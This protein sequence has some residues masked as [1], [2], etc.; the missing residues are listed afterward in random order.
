MQ[1]NCFLRG[2]YGY[3]V[4]LEVVVMV[5]EKLCSH[6]VM[7]QQNEF[8]DYPD[9]SK[10]AKAN[11]SKSFYLTPVSSFYN[12]KFHFLIV[13]LQSESAATLAKCFRGRNSRYLSSCTR[14]SKNF[15]GPNVP[16]HSWRNIL[17]TS[18]L[19]ARNTLAFG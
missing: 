10:H 19:R 17:Y 6:N 8:E 11:K 2:A 15:A 16:S 4:Q 9:Y 5:Y 3:R 14:P 13:I 12:L 7:T 18:L 1:I